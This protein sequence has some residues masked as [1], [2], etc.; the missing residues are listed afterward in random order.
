[1]ELLSLKEMQKVNL[2][3]LHE[4]DEICKKNNL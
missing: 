2:E 4:F 1:M 3:M